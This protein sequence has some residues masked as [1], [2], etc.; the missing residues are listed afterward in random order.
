MLICISSDACWHE[1]PE[2][3]MPKVLL[4]IQ[5]LRMSRLFRNVVIISN[6]DVLIFC[7]TTDEKAYFHICIKRAY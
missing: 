6:S 4:N 7:W 2:K 1:A 5:L 3:I